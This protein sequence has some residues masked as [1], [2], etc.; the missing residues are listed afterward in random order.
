MIAANQVLS[1]TRGVCQECGQIVNAQVVSDGKQVYLRK[2]CPQH[3]NQDVLIAADLQW[4]LKTID[5]PQLGQVI[6]PRHGVKEGCPFDCGLCAWHETSCMIPVFSV[7]N[8]CNLN[9]PICFTY[10]RPDKMYY[11]PESEMTEIVERL[12]SDFG[13]LDLINITGGEPTMHPDILKLLKIAKR[14][15]IGRITMNSNGIRLAEDEA[16]VE[17]LAELGVYVILSFNTMDPEVSNKMHGCDL[18]DI[19]MKAIANLAK[20]GVSATLLMVAAKG[21]NEH[22][23]G[24]IAKLVMEKDNLRSF[25]VQNMTYT[26]QGGCTFEPRQHITIDEVIAKMAEEPNLNLNIEDFQ[27]HPLSH[28]LCYST[29]YLLKNE[30]NDIVPFARLL[31]TSEYAELLSE[32]YLLHPDLKLEELM[33]TAVDRLWVNGGDAKHLKVLKDAVKS[34]YPVGKNLSIF[35]RQKVAEHFTKTIY[36]HSHMDADT[37]DLARICRCGDLVPQCDGRY[38]PACSYNMFY[39]Q[40]DENFW[41]ANTGE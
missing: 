13:S 32:G 39:R 12:I 18:V 1:L 15:E 31:E 28:P 36:I 38:V 21:I 40:Q 2:M 41:I 14:P 8:A 34:L 7:T 25:T 5:A 10:N 23:L 26:G 33:R 6:G 22:E 4:Y 30:A 11:M 17:Q 19:K 24:S 3:R 35:E 20:H 27:P 37:F 16:L 29:C 9:C